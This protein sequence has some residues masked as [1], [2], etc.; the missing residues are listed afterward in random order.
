MS[1]HIAT[2]EVPA[3][4]ASL[5]DRHHH[6]LRRLHSL[7]GI[8]PVGLFTI[9]HLFTNFQLATG[10]FQHEVN[11]IHSMPALFFLEVSIWGGIGFHAALGLVYTFTGKANVKNYTYAENVRYTLQRVTGILALIFIFIHVATLR[12]GWTFGGLF[13]TFYVASKDGHPLATAT[14]A[15]ALQSNWVLLLYVIGVSSVI[16]HFCNGLWTA[17]ITWGLTI[18]VQAQKRW[19]YACAALAAALTLFMVGAIVGARTYEITPQDQ[20]AMEHA[21]Q[22]GGGHYG[23]PAEE[24]SHD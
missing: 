5:M 10:D 15:R 11:F 20:A 2:T 22:H 13:D 23:K 21:D 17:A 6:L 7:S 14:T 16:Y 8:I 4:S 19:G 9:M 24:L 1:E 12:W 18:T 3:G